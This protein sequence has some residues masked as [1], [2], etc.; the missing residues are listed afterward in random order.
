ML[1]IIGNKYER[2][3]PV[4]VGAVTRTFLSYK[5]HGI[6]WVCTEVG[7]WNPKSY[8]PFINAFLILYFLNCLK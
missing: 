3:L 4:P 1:L 2:V 6:T 7:W 5:M 8:K